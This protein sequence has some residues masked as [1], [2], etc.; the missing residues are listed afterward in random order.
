MERKEETRARILASGAKLMRKQGIKGAGVA[1]VMGD[2]GLTVG[3]FYAHFKSKEDLVAEVFRHALKESGASTLESLPPGLAGGKKLRAFLKV[4]L[5][6][7]HRDS[8]REGRG[9]PVASL[10]GEMGKGSAALH[11]AY[12]GELEKYADH[13]A[14]FFSEGRFRLDRR[15]WLAV[16]S[17][18]VGALTLAR[19]SRGSAV[20]EEILEACLRQLNAFVA[21]KE[22][23]T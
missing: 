11:R 3:G 12:A 20:S 16:I 17:T 22:T 18:C 4:Y 6:P 1:R 19:A 7:R 5:S 10:S 9:C 14:G 21:S 23:V 2:A 8:D 15:D 13:R